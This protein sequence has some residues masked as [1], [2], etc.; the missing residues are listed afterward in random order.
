MEFLGQ[1]LCG[2]S[3]LSFISIQEI[4]ESDQHKSVEQKAKGLLHYHF[5]LLVLSGGFPV[6]PPGFFFYLHVC[7][8]ENKSFLGS[9]KL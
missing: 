5:P 3:C 2:D 1:H 8:S 6:W 7:T 4:C 9:I